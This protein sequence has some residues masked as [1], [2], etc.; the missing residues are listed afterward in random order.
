MYPFSVD[1]LRLDP[2]PV[3]AKGVRK[4]RRRTGKGEFLLGP[5]PLDWIQIA[6]ALPGKTM[7]V[8]L[9]CWFR[10]GLEKRLAI[11]LSHSALHKCGVGPQ[12]GYRG[13]MALEQAGLVSVTRARGRC[14]LVTIL[15]A[16]TVTHAR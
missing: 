15:D 3:R 16:P 7:A 2:S 9:A 14:P 8:G 4:A 11:T 10:V 12:A 1:N 5:I 13:L 6:G